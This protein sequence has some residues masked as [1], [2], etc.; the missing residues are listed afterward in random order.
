MHL[1]ATI[2]VLLVR[3]EMS[4]WSF[5]TKICVSSDYS[6]HYLMGS[7]DTVWL[8]CMYDRSGG[9]TWVWGGSYSLATCV[10]LTA[11][12][13]LIATKPV[14]QQAW[15]RSLVSRKTRHFF[16]RGGHVI[17]TNILLSAAI[18][19]T[20]CLCSFSQFAVLIWN[21]NTIQYNIRL[22]WVDKTQL[23]T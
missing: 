5:W 18:N 19:C 13:A 16:P 1:V 17:F 10:G 12:T 20:I 23:N 8:T 22:L 7:I 14:F 4:I 9:K 2:F 21:Y 3:T 15:L 11:R 6:M